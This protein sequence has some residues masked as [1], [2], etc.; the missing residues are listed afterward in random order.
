MDT[1][2]NS[3]SLQL[4]PKAI[5]REH[6]SGIKLELVRHGK[7]QRKP[8]RWVGSVEGHKYKYTVAGK[9]TTA[10]EANLQTHIVCMAPLLNAM[11]S[12]TL[13]WDFDISGR[14]T[15]GS[16]KPDGHA[17]LVGASHDLQVN[18]ILQTAVLVE[19]KA[20]SSLCTDDTQ[21]TWCAPHTHTLEPVL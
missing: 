13:F 7:L 6:M 21:G 14:P 9:W 4:S 16:F 15:L 17:R 2:T 20:T 11:P 10:T 18:N 12:T 1:V 3:T 5:L 19:L 8:A